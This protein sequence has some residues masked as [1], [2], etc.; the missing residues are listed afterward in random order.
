MMLKGR[1]V[2][3]TGSMMLI[4]FGERLGRAVSNPPGM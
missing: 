1:T 3:V 2:I 4:G